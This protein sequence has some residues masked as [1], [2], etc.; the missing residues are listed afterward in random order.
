MAGQFRIL[1]G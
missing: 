1:P